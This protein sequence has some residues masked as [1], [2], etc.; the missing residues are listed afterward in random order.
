MQWHLPWKKKLVSK[1]TI[2]IF[3]SELDDF[4]VGKYFA[5]SWP[6]PKACYW[7][8]FLKVFSPTLTEATEVEILFLKTCVHYFLSNFYFF[9]K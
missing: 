2:N 7:R 3:Y 4:N 8:I 9:I 5:V 1:L 6:K